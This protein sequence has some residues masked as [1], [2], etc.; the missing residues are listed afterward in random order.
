MNYMKYDLKRFDDNFRS[1]HIIKHRSG[2]A[3][4]AKG[5]WFDGAGNK[6][7]ELPKPEKLQDVDAF[8]KSKGK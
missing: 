6:F 2:I 4:I 5:L 1:L 7:I 3:N 8:L